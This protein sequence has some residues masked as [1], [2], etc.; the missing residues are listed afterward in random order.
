MPSDTFSGLKIY[1]IC[2]CALRLGIRPEPHWGGAYSASPEPLAGFKGPLC[3]KGRWKGRREGNKKKKGVGGKK[4]RER[5]ER[6]EDW[7][8]GRVA[9]WLL[10][11]GR[12]AYIIKL[13]HSV[14]SYFE[15]YERYPLVVAGDVV[16]A[17]LASVVVDEVARV[18]GVVV[19][20]MAVD[21]VFV[22]L[23]VV[24]V[25][26]IDVVVDGVVAVEVVV[27]DVVFVGLV[28]VEV[29]VVDVVIGGVVAVEVVVIDVVVVGVVV[30]VAVVV[31]V[32]VVIVVVGGGA[33]SLHEFSTTFCKMLL[34]SAKS[35]AKK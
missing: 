8:G 26:V 17:V 16:V 7:R 35:D 24:E 11:D 33:A 14:C 34:S 5:E 28:V 18:V 23:V 9:S 20:V 1:G 31:I 25:V 21:V 4:G 6:G 13:S 15:N 3:G 27:I 29:V 32:V 10:G 22:G 30:V 12:P 2:V 19:E